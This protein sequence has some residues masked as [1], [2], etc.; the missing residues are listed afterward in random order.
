MLLLR[1]RRTRV[2]GGAM[3]FFPGFAA[4]SRFAFSPPMPMTLLFA[5]SLSTIH[6]SKEDG[7][8]R[9]RCAVICAFSAHGSSAASSSPAFRQCGLH[10]RT[11]PAFAAPAFLH[12]TLILALLLFAEALP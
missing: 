6:A 7:A 10:P 9:K 12:R 8:R 4:P 3:L 2:A 11:P 5:M 1:R